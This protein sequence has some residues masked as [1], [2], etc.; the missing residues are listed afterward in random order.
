MSVSARVENRRLP[1]TAAPSLPRLGAI[2][3]LLGVVFITALFYAFTAERSRSLSLQASRASEEQRRLREEER[4]LR[5]ELNHLRS[6]QRLER[7]ALRLGLA[8]PT[9][10]Q[11]RRLK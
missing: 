4:R 8:R 9:P 7:E 5:V 11:I 10:G 2:L 3:L 1:M 6:P